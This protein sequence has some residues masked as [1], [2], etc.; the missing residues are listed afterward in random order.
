M[1]AGF[2]HHSRSC[3]TVLKTGSSIDYRKD[4]KSIAGSTYNTIMAICRLTFMENKV[5]ACIFVQLSFYKFSHLLIIVN[6]AN[7]AQY[8]G[9]Q[10][11]F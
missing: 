10:P 5:F 6:A 2:I 3:A 11:L 8:I 9:F 7:F 4:H 1:L